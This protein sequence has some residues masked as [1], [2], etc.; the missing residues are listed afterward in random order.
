MLT[1]EDVTLLAERAMLGALLVDPAPL[2]ELDAWVRGTDFSEPWHR[3]VW[4]S[5]RE[6]HVA[7]APTDALSLGMRM[8]QRYGPRI[9]DLPRLHLLLHDAPQDP[10]PRP[11]ARI[12]VDA[13]VRRDVDGQGILLR[14]TALEASMS[15]EG[16]P[17]RSALRIAGA[18]V[19]IACERWADAN[20]EVTDR[21]T[22]QIPAR[23]RAGADDLELRRAADKFVA[24]YPGIDLTEVGR[25][26]QRLVANLATHPTAISPT[27]AW[28]RPDQLTNR[29]WATVYSALA[30]LAAGGQT[31]DPTMVAMATVRIA[32]DTGVAP[33]LPALMNSVDY[34]RTS[35]PGHLRQ[36][37]AGDHLRLAAAQGTEAL[38]QGATSP[39]VPIVDLLQTA[40]ALLHRMQHLSTA[41]PDQID[42]GPLGRRRAWQIDPPATGPISEGP[43]AG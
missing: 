36:I 32:H 20:G 35:V 43:A 38:H 18:A 2:R 19:L 23:L 6:A 41:L 26:E 40:T 34:E 5:M 7:G 3:Q 14:A 11:H 21:L 10:D 8:L 27:V 12:V 25:D 22:A 37:V 42:V 16:R 33:S 13:G 4:I 30:E 31:I 1:R 9:A 24:D 17:L 28:I 39:D 15:H 29:P